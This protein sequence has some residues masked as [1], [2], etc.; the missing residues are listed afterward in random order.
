M[1]SAAGTSTQTEVKYKGHTQAIKI[2][3]AALVDLNVNAAG[4]LMSKHMHTGLQKANRQ[5]GGEQPVADERFH[6]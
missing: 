3:N 2:C 6:E 1:C 4:R 5:D